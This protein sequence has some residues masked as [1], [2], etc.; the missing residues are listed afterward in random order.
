MEFKKGHLYWHRSAKDI[1]FR[2]MDDPQDLGDSI[3]FTVW[4]WNW[5]HK[6]FQGDS[7]MVT[8]KKCD[9]GNWSE[10]K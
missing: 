3:R 1:N 7:E 4:Y 10:V 2:V 6:A 8:V 5:F 9:L